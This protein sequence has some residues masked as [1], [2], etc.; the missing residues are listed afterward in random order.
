MFI[1]GVTY[2][3]ASLITDVYP[4][5]RCLINA[6]KECGDK[7]K[8]KLLLYETI[9]ATWFDLHRDVDTGEITWIKIY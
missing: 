7:E 5:I 6:W 8:Q 2:L 3:K 9:N 4:T 1:L